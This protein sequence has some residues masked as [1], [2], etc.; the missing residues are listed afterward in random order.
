LCYG[1]GRGILGAGTLADYED[2]IP[3][4]PEIKAPIRANAGVF[5]RPQGVPM[6]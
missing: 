5:G 4:K 6:D 2:E 1:E 3:D